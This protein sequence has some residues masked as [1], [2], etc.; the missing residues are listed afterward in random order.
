[1]RGVQRLVSKPELLHPA[2]KAPSS[3]HQEQARPGTGS[4]FRAWR[5]PLRRRLLALADVAAL[6]VGG[7]SLG[8]A[9]GSD[10]E[11]MIWAV[12]ILP[13]W[14]VVAKL[15]GLYDR[16][17]TEL[18]HLTVDELPSIF[19]WTLTATVG[20]ALI[21][22]VTP[23]GGPSYAE[24]LRLGISTG[25]GAFVFRALA[26]FTWR[27]LTAPE[28][29]F[30]LGSGPLADAARR[31]LELFPDIHA[32]AV[33][34]PSIGVSEALHDPEL[35]LGIGI[36]RIIVATD[37]INEQLIAQLVAM[38][39]FNRIKLS[40]VPPAQGM[41]GTAVRLAH[42][43]D[44]PMLEYNTW[45]VP[46]STLFLKRCLDL[47]V[48]SATL[49]ILS[50]L[51]LLVALVVFL[52]SPG[53]VV[54]SQIRVGM[55]GRCFRMRKFR[56]MVRD[57]EARLGEVVTLGALSEPMFK[58]R[59][60]P[61]VTRV[62]RLLRR[63]SL[64]ELPQLFNVLMGDMSLVGP[65][66]EQVELVDL[67]TDEQCFRLAVKPG[68]TGPMQVYGRGQLTFQ[69]RLAVERDYIENLSLGRDLRILALT[70]PAVLGGRGAF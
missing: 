64:D 67:Y 65:R 21:L 17:H 4:S 39:R 9:S 46:R 40:V 1:M 6:I 3:G 23:A 49:L 35:L 29:V 2:V 38:C 59:D 41:F 13:V 68:L 58:V 22:R 48:S 26:R 36:D 45:D 32:S 16:D 15:Y 27:R 10:G 8:L 44:L 43:A 28:R 61:R 53:T 54:F 33:D 5:D 57:A 19:F 50:P 42:V 47:A 12:V 18:R 24:A 34:D 11:R 31:K 63:T 30:V 66:P 55:Q 7:L 62:G 51:L 37:S 52:D 25:I 60:D 56:T 14:L 20:T 70:L 69:E